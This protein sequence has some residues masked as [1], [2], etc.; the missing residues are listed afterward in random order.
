MIG[1]K[2]KDSFDQVRDAFYLEF[3]LMFCQTEGSIAINR[4][5]E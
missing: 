3:Y 5:E 4:E 1:G 2:S